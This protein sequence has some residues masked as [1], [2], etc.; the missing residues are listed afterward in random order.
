MKYYL[1]WSI[2]LGILII[3]RDRQGVRRFIE[4]AL[5]K[6][7][8][9]FITRIMILLINLGFSLLTTRQVD[10]VIVASVSVVTICIILIDSYHTFWERPWQVQ[11]NFLLAYQRKTME[12]ASTALQ[13]LSAWFTVFCLLLCY[14]S[15]DWRYKTASQHPHFTTVQNGTTLCDHVQAQNYRSFL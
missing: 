5:A 4:L 14:L 11:Q 10:L 2:V 9:G 1:G 8:R 3:F 15:H 12:H 7:F 13:R 6:S